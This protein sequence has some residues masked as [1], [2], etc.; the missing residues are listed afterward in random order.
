MK[1]KLFS[2]I[3]CLLL[4]FC[5]EQ[6]PIPISI[7]SQELL[8]NIQIIS[9]DSMQGREFSTIGSLKAQKFIEKKFKEVGLQKYNSSSYINK[10]DFTF[11]GKLRQQ[12]FPILDPGINFINVKDTIASGANVIGFLKGK[13]NKTIVVTAHYDHLG[14][15]NDEIY[16][17]AD[18]NA[19]GV[20]ALF[21]IAEY[22][23]DK[24]INHDIVFAAVDGEEIGCV[25]TE[26]FL[27]NQKKE[28]IVLNINL[29][30]ISHNDFYP[31][32]YICGTY[33]HP[34]LKTYLKKVKSDSVTILFGHDDPEILKQSD[35][36][37][38]S[39]HKVFYKEN[40]PFL[41]FGVSDHKDYHRPT[42]TYATINPEFYIG[43]V[44]VIIKSIETLDEKLAN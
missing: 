8:E 15:R 4:F 44:K 28:N 7:N 17:G 40:I 14:I 34:I 31:E 39:D 36:T 10:F 9:N 5:C 3:V 2:G 41:Y 33:H 12:A 1:K 19:S 30:M 24:P 21:A 38:S 22:F 16:N 43:A 27:Q 20:A 18:D 35:W 26:V 29:D 6:V 25:G 32:L 13:T 37:L 23:K 42:D 11:K